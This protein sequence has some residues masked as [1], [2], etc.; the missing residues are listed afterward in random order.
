MTP[1]AADSAPTQRGTRRTPPRPGR[2]L[3]VGGLCGELLRD[4]PG[5]LGR[6]SAWRAEGC[7]GR[8]ALGTAGG[9]TRAASWRNEE[10]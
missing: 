1:A 2:R 6:R 9:C 10:S 4:L 5:A 7:T 3:W 8:P